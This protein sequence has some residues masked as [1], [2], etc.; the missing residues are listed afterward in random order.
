M[1]PDEVAFELR[2]DITAAREARVKL[3]SLEGLSSVDLAAVKTI[4]SVLVTR[5]MR[6]DCPGPYGVKVVANLSGAEGAE[7]SVRSSAGWSSLERANENETRKGLAV[8]DA[9]SRSWW[10]DGDR[11]RFSVA[12]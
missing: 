7:G 5:A 6:E 4:V 10:I 11:V 9:F 3:S 12:S 2:S 1:A 8:L